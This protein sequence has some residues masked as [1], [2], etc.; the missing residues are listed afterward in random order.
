MAS[1]YFEN[2]VRIDELKVVREFPNV[3]PDDI[4]GI[5]PKREVEF[6]IDLVP[7][8]IPVYMVPYRMPASDLSELK[9][10]LEELLEKKF[11]RP[12]VS[13]RGAPVLLVKKKDGISF[14]GH[15]ISG[16]GIAVDPSKVNVVLQWETPKSATEIRSFLGLADYYRRFIE[17]FSKL[18]LSLMRLTC[19]GKAFVWDVQCGVLIQISKVVT[20]ASR[21]LRIHEKNYPTHDLELA[22]DYDF[23]LNYHPGK[24]NVVADAL[25]RKTL[26]MSAMMVK[27]L[28]LT[29]QL[30]DMSLVCK[31]TPHSVMLGMLKI[32]NDFLDNIREAQKL[33]VKLVDL[34]VGTDRLENGD[35]KLMK[36]THFI[37][38]NITF[39]IAKLAE[40]YVRVIVK[41][42]GVP[43]CIVSY[44]DPR[45]TSNF[46][47]SLQQISN[48]IGKVAYRVALPPNI[49]NLHDV[50]HMSQL[51]KYVSDPSHVIQVDDVHV[52]DNLTVETMHVRIVN[53]DMKVLRGK[54]IALVKVVWLGAAAESLT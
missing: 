31:V 7:G 29:E 46:W 6:A 13:P 38:I 16:S 40:I 43:L 36:S 3:I 14:L 45:F 20:Y 9:K 28:E 53:R 34:M 54:E 11:I 47:K 44:R 2:Q 23:C 48:R 33:D 1:L 30:R 35:F 8:T 12:S 5:P 18:A 52:R 39:P 37:P 51:R 41:F 21:Q 10:Q 50:F 4:L 25:S 19:K 15:V 49:A 22:A 17:G 24:A 32:N 26:H 27:E 42:H